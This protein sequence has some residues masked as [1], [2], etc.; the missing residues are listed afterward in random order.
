M[1]NENPRFILVE[2]GEYWLDSARFSIDV[3]EFNFA[4]AQARVAANAA[5][6]AEW[7]ERAISIYH[8]EY[9][10]N[11]YYEWVFP[12]RRRLGQAYLTVL[13]ELA[14]Y[15]L[16]VQSSQQALLLI[17][18]A[19]PLDLLNEDLYCLAMHAYAK[20]GDRANLARVYS[21]LEQ[22]LQDELNTKPLAKTANL[23]RELQKSNDQR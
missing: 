19:I 21:E 3:D 13:R 2:V 11:L 22:R 7:Q 1:E 15:H 4:L 6:R 12:E 5:S 10:Q 14:V 16:S 20:T 17:E 23:Y 9:L 18:K 8:G